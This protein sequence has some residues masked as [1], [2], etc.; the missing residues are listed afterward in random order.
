LAIS[1]AKN[2]IKQHIRPNC[3][4][5]GEPFTRD[6]LHRKHCSKECYQEFRLAPKKVAICK[7]CKKKFVKTIK[8]HKKVFCCKFCQLLWQ[9]INSRKRGK[10]KK[11]CLY[12]GKE[13]FSNYNHRTRG[14]RCCSKKCTMLRIRQKKLISSGRARLVDGKFVY[15]KTCKMC[16]K[17]FDATS[18]GSNNSK[19]CS[20]NCKKQT[21]PLLTCAVCGREFHAKNPKTRLCSPECIRINKITTVPKQCPV[22]NKVFHPK[23][24]KQESCSKIC[25]AKLIKQRKLGVLYEPAA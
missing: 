11:N 23:P 24:Q 18:I 19:Y 8:N 4:N 1:R 2:D 6:F 10:R 14:H 3:K 15:T 21:L 13:F 25:A 9:A 22:C 7:R 20:P 17:N 16:G 12:C 5:C